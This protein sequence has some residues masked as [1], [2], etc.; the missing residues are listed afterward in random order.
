[1]PAADPGAAPTPAGTVQLASS[2]AATTPMGWFAGRMP[3]LPV[4]GSRPRGPAAQVRTG[5]PGTTAPP[6]IPQAASIASI[7]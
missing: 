3:A 6:P 7:A 2:T 1:M 4:P 5:L